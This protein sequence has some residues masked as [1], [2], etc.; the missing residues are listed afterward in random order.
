MVA[1]KTVR[2]AP[3]LGSHGGARLSGALEAGA[4][5]SDLTQ[6]LL[7]AR[8]MA[9]LEHPN[10]VKL[11]G[12]CVSRL[13]IYLVMELC[14]HGS[15]KDFLRARP[16]CVTRDYVG[17]C[18]DMALQSARGIAYLHSKMCIHRDLAAR[19]VL[20][21]DAVAVA[22]AVAPRCGHQLKLADLGLSRR[23]VRR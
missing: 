4:G 6:I 13:P 20:V 23:L 18:I 17:A 21:D 11:L 2:L 8:L 19:N 12:V 14:A 16:V 7:E 22:G 10:L 1:V 9:V 3:T 5:F 15:L